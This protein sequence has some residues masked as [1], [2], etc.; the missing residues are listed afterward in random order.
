MRGNDPQSES[1][2][3]VEEIAQRIGALGGEAGPATE[4]DRRELEAL[5][6]R[7]LELQVQRVEAYRRLCRTRGLDLPAAGWSRPGAWRASPAV[8]ARAFKEPELELWTAQPRI[9]FRSS[10]TTAGAHRRS[11]HHH[12]HPELYRRIVEASFPGACIDQGLLCGRERVPMLSLVPSLHD[13]P[14]SS[15]G[16]MIDHVLDRWGANDSLSALGTG[17]LDADGARAFLAE[18]AKSRRPVLV[19]STAL[20][21]ARL[22]DALEERPLDHAL[23]PGS[24]IFETGGFKGSERELAR[25]DLLERS[26]DRLGVPPS[27]IVR[28]YGMTELTSQA[29]TRVLAG[30]DPDTFHAPPWLFWW[31]VDPST[32]EPVAPRREGLIAFFDLG[33]VG[34]ISHLL[35]EDVGRA[36]GDGGFELVGRA[37]DA[38]LRGCSLTAEELLR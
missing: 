2:E 21:L 31:L 36:A 24:V 6:G 12:P 9:V 26:L 18:H 14:D 16:F 7:V 5:A 30:G 35:T 37:S 23:A 17:G 15:L 3:L 28:E 33:N 4:A 20:A 11:E 8:P 13:V 25:D 32:G 10:G 34:S 29:Y 1:D 38:E 27:R 19:L 22:L